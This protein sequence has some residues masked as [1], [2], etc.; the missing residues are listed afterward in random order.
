MI[1]I[2]EC[3]ELRALFTNLRFICTKMATDLD[4]DFIR[5]EDAIGIKDFPS[6]TRIFEMLDQS[7][8]GQVDVL[9]N[10]AYC[11]I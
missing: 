2:I 11:Y 9:N 3:I 4:S 1:Q 8:P 7:F 6:A 5:G 10:L